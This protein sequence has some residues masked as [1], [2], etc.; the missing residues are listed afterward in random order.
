MFL[1]VEQVADAV[2]VEREGEPESLVERA[3]L[4]SGNHVGGI[5]LDDVESKA[6]TKAKV[7][8]VTLVLILI[9][10]TATQEELLVVAIFST[11]REGYFASFLLCATGSIAKRLEDTGD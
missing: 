9:E 1:L 7:L 5:E 10:E 8:A 6:G 4:G 2:H 3:V 11:N